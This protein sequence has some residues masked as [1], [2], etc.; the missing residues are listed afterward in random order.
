MDLSGR[1]KGRENFKLIYLTYIPKR[2]K[3]NPR[4]PP[5]PPPHQK[6]AFC[7]NSTCCYIGCDLIC[8]NHQS[9]QSVKTELVFLGCLQSF[10]KLKIKITWKTPDILTKKL[11]PNCGCQEPSSTMLM[12]PQKKTELADSKMFWIDGISL[13]LKVH[14]WK[15]YFVF[16]WLRDTLYF[17]SSRNSHPVMTGTGNAR[18]S[19]YYPTPL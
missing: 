13:K 4:K 10:R 3:Q 12:M 15:V 14:S 8:Q 17:I 2:N 5:P 11:L 16:V 1:Q 6:K 9:C 19:L 7:W 18:L